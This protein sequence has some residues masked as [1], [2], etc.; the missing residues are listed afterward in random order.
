MLNFMCILLILRGECDHTPG[1][2]GVTEKDSWYIY[3]Q[4]SDQELD[5]PIINSEYS[6]TCDYF[7]KKNYVKQKSQLSRE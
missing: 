7:K 5:E 3:L 6:T 1:K 4:G 2:A